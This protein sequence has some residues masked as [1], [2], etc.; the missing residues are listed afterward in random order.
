MRF[1]FATMLMT[2]TACNLP[3]NHSQDQMSKRGLP[4]LFWEPEDISDPFG[5][6]EFRAEPLQNLGAASGYPSYAVRLPSPQS[7]RRQLYLWVDRPKLGGFKQ[8][9]A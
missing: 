2:T 1:I 5:S 7:R 9:S 4:L 6:I 8:P 3:V